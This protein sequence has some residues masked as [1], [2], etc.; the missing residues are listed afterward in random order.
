MSGQLSAYMPLKN[1]TS[2]TIPRRP[3]CST[4]ARSRAKYSGFQRSRSK[5]YESS[6]GAARPGCAPF[7]AERAHGRTCRPGRGPSGFPSTYLSGASNIPP[8]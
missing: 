6:P 3:A 8:G 4:N 2:T 5:R 1:A 7:S